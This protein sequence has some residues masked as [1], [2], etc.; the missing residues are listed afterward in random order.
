MPSL[1]G[2]EST[3][4]LYSFIACRHVV[5]K[6]FAH[7]FMD[8]SSSSYVIQLDNSEMNDDKARNDQKAQYGHHL[9]LHMHRQ[10]PKPLL[11]VGDYR[12][13]LEFKSV[14]NRIQVKSFLF[15]LHP[16]LTGG[17]LLDWKSHEATMT[18]STWQQKIP[19]LTGTDWGPGTSWNEKF[20]LQK[21]ALTYL[22]RQRI[23]KVTWLLQ[24]GHLN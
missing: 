24:D 1:W 21:I 22:W 6:V 19:N 18:S 7:L 23:L 11:Y 15:V 8:R 2:P 20:P 13:C 10:A 9:W 16:D 12:H 4:Y 5:R 14:I 3:S 17:R